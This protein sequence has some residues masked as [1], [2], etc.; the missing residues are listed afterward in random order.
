LRR[1]I[2][3]PAVPA[4]EVP[5]NTRLV[6]FGFISLLSILLLLNPSTQQG[7]L[8]SSVWQFSI[9]GGTLPY[10]ESWLYEAQPVQ[11]LRMNTLAI[12]LTTP[13][14]YAV[15][16]SPTDCTVGTTCEDYYLVQAV[17]AINWTIQDPGLLQLPNTPIYHVF[18]EPYNWTLPFEENG[19]MV[20]YCRVYGDLSLVSFR[21]CAID[22]FD[23]QLNGNTTVLGTFLLLLLL[24]EQ[25]LQHVRLTVWLFSPG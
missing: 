13:E 5:S 1:W 2:G 21:V 17:A 24:T 25:H 18:T 12:F 23:T 14:Q 6:I 19:D 16:V 8:G 10:N 11:S 7:C 20:S 9:P 22:V 15:P 3:S 4:I